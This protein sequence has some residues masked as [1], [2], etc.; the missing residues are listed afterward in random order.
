M[1]QAVYVVGMAGSGKST[2]TG[3]Y[4]EWL[5]SQDQ[6]VIAIN[7]DPGATVLPYNPDVDARKYVDVQKLMS[8]YTLG[9]N[10]A[11]IMASDILANHVEDMRQEIKEANPQTVLV[12]TPG[13][14]ELF[15]F[16]EGGRFIANELIEENIAVIYLLDAPFTRS[17]LNLISNFYLAAAVYSRI[18]R[19]QVYVL[20]KSDLVTEEE[21]EKIIGWH[22]DPESLTQELSTMHE[23]NLSLIARDLA[24]AVF[25]TGLISEPIPISARN[26]SG[27][28]NVESAITRILN[29]GDE[30]YA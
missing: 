10:G 3:A 14:I 7:L 29:R 9:P 11:L 24:E 19:P 18:N 27:F 25:T 6:D 4:L 13:Q 8:D 28:L 22:T 23:S 21:V 16:R 15:A 17:P 5:R 30:P 1:S 12:D 26:N 2:F 20:S